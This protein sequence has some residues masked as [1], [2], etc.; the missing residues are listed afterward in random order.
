M[1]T[2]CWLGLL[3]DSDGSLTLR[4]GSWVSPNVVV[5]VLAPKKTVGENRGGKYRVHMYV[6]IDQSSPL[7]ISIFLP[8][9]SVPSSIYL[10][11]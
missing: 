10:N 5:G 4:E 7:P 11:I 3:M 1:A 6:V 2:E 8:P 9:S